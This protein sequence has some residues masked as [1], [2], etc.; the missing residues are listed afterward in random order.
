MHVSVDTDDLRTLVV[1]SK[2]ENLQDTAA[3]LGINQRS[4]SRII[5]RLEH[6]LGV[7]LFVWRQRKLRPTEAGRLF[8]ER[9]EVVLAILRDA[10]EQM[11][12]PKSVIERLDVIPDS[13]GTHEG[14]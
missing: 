14:C 3:A 12:A 8:T 7:R 6:Q 11:H 9:A 4:L 2:F 1:L 13:G 10:A 5:H